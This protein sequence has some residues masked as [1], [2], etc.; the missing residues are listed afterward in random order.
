MIRLYR[1]AYGNSGMNARQVLEEM[2]CDAMGKMNAFATEETSTVAGEVGQFLRDL[3]KTALE[4]QTDGQKNSAQEGVKFS[5]E[6]FDNAAR[7]FDNEISQWDNDGRDGDR[8]FILGTTGEILQGLGAVENDIYMNGDKINTILEEHPEM[9]LSE[10]K[11]IPQILN[12]PTLILKSRNVGRRGSQNTRMVLFGTA[13]A[14]NNLPIMVIFD[15]RPTE[16]H[17]VVTDM[18]KVTSAYTKTTD[19]VGFVKNSFVMYADKKRA[20]PLL[21]TIGFHTPI[22]LRQGGYVGSIA[23]NKQNVNL[24]GELEFR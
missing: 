7:Q 4:T 15:V 5:R 12:D 18:Q 21:R 14:Q 10:I 17:F 20:T 13:K 6:I 3:R 8:Q 24:Y 22:E 19:A 16:G 23:Y 9:T 11:Q 2:V 1:A